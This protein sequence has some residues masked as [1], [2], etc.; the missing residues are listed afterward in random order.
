MTWKHFPHYW[1]FGNGIRHF[2]ASFCVSLFLA[3]RSFWTN[4]WIADHLRRYDVTVMWQLYLGK[5]FPRK[6]TDTLVKEFPWTSKKAARNRICPRRLSIHSNDQHTIEKTCMSA[7]WK[8]SHVKY[9]LQS[10]NIMTPSN[11]NIFRVTGHLCGEFTRHRWIPHTKAVARS[12]DVFFDLRLIK[13]LSKQSRGWK[14]DTP[15]RPL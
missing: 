13:W 11:G 7:V 2:R 14:F 1:L 3:W 15:Y 5:C 8:K 10:L 4:N 12:F 9:C 6:N